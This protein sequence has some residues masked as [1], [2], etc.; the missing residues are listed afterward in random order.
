[1]DEKG[2][3]ILVEAP[4]TRANLLGI[5]LFL[6]AAT[7]FYGNSILLYRVAPK[8]PLL[9]IKEK[10]RFHFSIEKAMGIDRF[11]LI[12]W[13]KHPNSFYRDFYN[14]NCKATDPSEFEFFEYKKVLI[15]D[16]IYD[17]FL[18][19]SKKKT[20]DFNDGHFHRIFY[21]LISYFDEYLKVF[22]KYQVNAVIVSNCVY[23]FAIPLRIGCSLEIPCYQ[24][25]S[26][27]IYR[28]SP[29]R[30]HAYTEF[31][32]YGNHMCLKSK[33]FND[34]LSEVKTRIERRFA[35]EVG[36]DMPYSTKSAFS[37]SN[38]ILFDTKDSEIKI[39]VATHDFFDSP[40]S[41]GFNFYPD[42]YVWLETLGR[43]SEKTN[44]KWYLKTHPD[45]IGDSDK[46][47]IELEKRFPKFEVIP[48]DTSHHELIKN[49]INIALTVFGTIGWE[50][51][52]L[53]IPTI[54]ASK[55]NPHSKFNFSITPN[56]RIEY[57]MIL[58]NLVKYKDYK[59]KKS[60]IEQFYFLHNYKK[61][62]SFIY[63]NNQQYLLEIGGYQNSTSSQ[64]LDYYVTCKENNK[65]PEAE[66]LSGISR[67]IKSGDFKLD[68][69][70]GF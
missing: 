12:V 57:E 49:G 26:E 28:L 20:L 8:S 65:R 13:Q 27:S 15:G 11:K 69:K 31:L 18:R 55:N 45:P 6:G 32:D 38:R 4:A 43:I 16:L 51:P 1:V 17:E 30:L 47:L 64:A 42:F 53:G 70:H 36:V 61:L 37:H 63:K 9:W 22:E 34:S 40:H 54:N 44:Y 52:A 59:I 23:H 66:I 46:V 67:F 48:S 33:E 25:T 24:V 50:Y 41:Y 21:E 5:R 56:N 14:Y 2:K 19:R 10:L 39:L 60:E 7:K 62:H 3:L 35:G 58:L 68:Y 29:S